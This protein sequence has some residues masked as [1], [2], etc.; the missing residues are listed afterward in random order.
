MEL[1]STVLN[2]YQS[3]EISAL[4]WIV[5]LEFSI[6][7]FMCWKFLSFFEWSFL[8]SFSIGNM[9]FAKLIFFPPKL[10]CSERFSISKIPKKVLAGKTSLAKK[11]RAFQFYQIGEAFE[12]FKL[13]LKTSSIKLEGSKYFIMTSETLQQN[14][15]R[16]KHNK[17]H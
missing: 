5:I 1:E 17:K 2:L 14:T 16:K 10:F 4:N 11:V 9:V 3:N 6:F 7:D 8:E 13:Q 15:H 12:S